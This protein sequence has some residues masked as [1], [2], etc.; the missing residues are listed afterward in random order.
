MQSTRLGSAGL[1]ISRICLGMMSYGDTSR[2]AWHLDADAAE[3][4]VA[5]AAEAGVTCAS[6]TFASGVLILTK[7]KVAKRE[8]SSVSVTPSFEPRSPKGSRR[9]VLVSDRLQFQPTRRLERQ[10]P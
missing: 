9:Q 6:V 3:P 10:M 4:I 2:R 1:A 8:P 7:P 5:A